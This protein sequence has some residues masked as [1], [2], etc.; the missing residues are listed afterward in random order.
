MF[1]KINEID[2]GL[3]TKHIKFMIAMKEFE[4]MLE[5]IKWS[6]VSEKRLLN[7]R[8]IHNIKEHL[9]KMNETVNDINT[10]IKASSHLNH[11][12]NLKRLP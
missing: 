3:I 11:L 7:T 12:N 1:E 2:R 5:Y 10:K 4:F 6:I 9:K 8:L